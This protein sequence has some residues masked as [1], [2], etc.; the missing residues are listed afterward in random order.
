MP[1]FSAR[2]SAQLATCNPDLQRL[3]SEVVQHYDCTVIEGHRGQESQNKAY[4]EGKSKLKWP[5]GNHNAYPSRAVDVAPYP[6]DW[7]DR[8]RFLHFAGFVFGIASQMGIKLRYGGD[9]DGDFKFKGP[10]LVDLPHFELVEIEHIS[11][12]K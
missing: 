11:R 2:S 4:L 9:W 5:H 12:T 8:D 6:L 7:N 10:G 1:A 3:F